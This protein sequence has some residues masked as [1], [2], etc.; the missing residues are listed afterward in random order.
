MRRD[1]IG[2]AILIFA[3]IFI[4]AGLIF[5]RW[6]DFQHKSDV[7]RVLNA[8]SVLQMR[9]TIDYGKP[10][11]YQERYVMGNQNGTSSAQYQITGYSGRVVTITLPP[12]KTYAVT[13]FFEQIVADGA[14]QLMNKPPRGNTDVRYT[15][16]IH[17]VA[18]N[19][20]GSRTVTFTDPH[21][22]AVTAGRQ[23][24][25]HMSPGGPTPDILKMSS[26]SMADPRYEKIVS[27]FRS[28]GSPS[29]R[30]KVAQAQQLVQRSR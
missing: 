12:D 25:I 4:A 22:W 20:S 28:F 7:A 23:Y 21:Y 10:P 26:T 9:L 29:F 3:V 18:D 17:Q 24:E 15:F 1:W 13:F 2:T 30:T 19:K 5:I 16:W 8:R 14:W 27:A 6:P 11:I